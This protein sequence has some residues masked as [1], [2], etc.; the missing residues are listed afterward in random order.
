MSKQLPAGLKESLE[1]SKAEYRQLG[2]SGLRV[3]VPIFGCMSFGDKR[4]LPWVIGEDEA[5]PLLKAAYDRGLNTWDTANVYSNGAS[6]V[7]VG[8]A[9]KKYNIPRHKVVI[10][11]KAHWAVGEEPGRSPVCCEVRVTLS[12][13]APEARHFVNRA[14]FEAS[15]DYQNN[16]GLSRTALFNQVEASLQRLDT[17]YIDL[18]QI[19][20]FDARTPLEETMKALHDLVQSGKV[21]YIGA[22]SMWATQFARLQFVAEKNGWTPFVSMQTSTPAVPRESAR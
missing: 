17:P 7:I 22:S 1:N 3:S 9:I 14:E 4:T 5:L 2:K 18:L 10:L 11:T 8:K 12:D 20:R 13:Q 15:K 6:E 16:F 21:R 19:H